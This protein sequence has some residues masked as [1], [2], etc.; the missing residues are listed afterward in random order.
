MLYLKTTLIDLRIQSCDE[1]V[2]RVRIVLIKTIED[3]T[4]I[5]HVRANIKVVYQQVLGLFPKCCF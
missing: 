2:N 3:S 1:I 4:F 5:N